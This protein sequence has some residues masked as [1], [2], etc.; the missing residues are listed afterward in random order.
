MDLDKVYNVDTLIFEVG[1]TLLF[2]AITDNHASLT[3]S[4]ASDLQK[5]FLSKFS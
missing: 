4:K 3:P 5:G 1:H 2:T